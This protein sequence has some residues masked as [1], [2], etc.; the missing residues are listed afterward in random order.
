MSRLNLRAI[1]TQTVPFLARPQGGLPRGELL[2]L[3]PL[4]S[5]EVVWEMKA[6]DEEP[7]GAKLTV[8]RRDDRVGQML[9]RVFQIPATKTIELDEVNAQIWARCDGATSVDQLIKYTCATY[10][11]NRRQGEVGVV[12]L[13]KM[14]GQRRLIGFPGGASPAASKEG[15]A[16]H[17]NR[18]D[19]QRAQTKKR[20]RRH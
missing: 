7:P 11:L 9:S 2:A 4:R 15:V 1:L 17:V 8:P 6:E 10:K 12:T 5:P 19:R 14:L 20:R 18:S 13:M 3:K 16:S